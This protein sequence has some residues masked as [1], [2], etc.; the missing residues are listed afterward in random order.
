M[1]GVLC[2]SPCHGALENVVVSVTLALFLLCACLEVVPN[3][4]HPGSDA[5]VNW[6]GRAG[7]ASGVFQ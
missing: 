2:F 6:L 4:P 5:E 3:L 1:I 7:W